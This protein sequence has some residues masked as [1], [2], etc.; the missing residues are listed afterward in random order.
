[1]TIGAE[2]KNCWWIL[3]EPTAATYWGGQYF[4]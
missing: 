4:G 2:S 3:K 1:V